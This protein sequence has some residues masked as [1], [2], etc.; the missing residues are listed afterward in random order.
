MFENLFSVIFYQ[1]RFYT[2]LKTTF[3]LCVQTMC[4][5][6]SN[7]NFS[8]SLELLNCLYSQRQIICIDSLWCSVGY[9]E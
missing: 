1:S 9:N 7:N 2:F 6:I 3:I 4:L 8:Y 5:M